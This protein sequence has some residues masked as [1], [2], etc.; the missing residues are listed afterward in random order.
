MPLLKNGKLV[1]GTCATLLNLKGIV[2]FPIDCCHRTAIG[3][4]NG[5][6]YN[7]PPGVHYRLIAK[8]AFVCSQG[9]AIQHENPWP[10]EPF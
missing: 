8:N 10:A 5:C 1:L 3:L 4:V 9:G 6:K 2:R 7:D